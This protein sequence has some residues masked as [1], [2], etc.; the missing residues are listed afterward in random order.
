MVAPHAPERWVRQ[1][2]E[3][4]LACMIWLAAIDAAPRQQ[5]VR[6][7][8]KAN[9]NPALHAVPVVD[10][11]WL[12]ETRAVTPDD[13]PRSP[14][15]AGRVFDLLCMLGTTPRYKLPVITDELIGQVLEAFDAGAEDGLPAAP[16]SEVST[17]LEQ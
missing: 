15:S 14:G 17:F 9:A 8:R 3:M 5:Q 2:C 11:M 1:R 4:A 10:R 7:F 6:T 12:G 16:R 13:E